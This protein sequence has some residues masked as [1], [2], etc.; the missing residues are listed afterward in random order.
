[1][2]NFSE[3]AMF[4]GITYFIE[5]LEDVIKERRASKAVGSLKPFLQAQRNFNLFNIL[6]VIKSVLFSQEYHDFIEIAREAIADYTREV[7]GK[8]VPMWNEE[9]VDEIVIAQVTQSTVS[10]HSN[11]RLIENSNGNFIFSLRCSCWPDLILL[12]PL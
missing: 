1:M 7:D 4:G 2:K 11:W 10:S 9:E 8:Q 5:I 3:R 12:P 6:K